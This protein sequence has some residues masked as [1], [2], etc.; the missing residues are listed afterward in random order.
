MDKKLVAVALF[1]D[2]LKHFTLNHNIL[3][4]KLDYCGV[5]GL[6]LNWF[7]SYLMLCYHYTVINNN[8]SLCSIMESS[9]SQGSI[10]GPL[11]YIIYVND[12]F[13]VESNV[14]CV[15]H[16]DDTVLILRDKDINNLFK[17]C[18]QFF[19]LYSVWFTDNKLAVMLRK[20]QLRNF[21]YWF[22]I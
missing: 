22:K 20:N 6:A 16:A 11:L 21:F 4:H 7:K 12:V 9:T 15:L 13:N 3:L 19:A 17:R 18:S 10:L 1:V 2:V 14:K 8:C 5:H